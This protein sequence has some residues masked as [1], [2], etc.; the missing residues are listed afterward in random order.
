MTIEL[1]PSANRRPPKEPRLIGRWIVF[2]LVG[3]MG[4][5]IQLATLA[6]LTAWAGVHYLLA[7][8]VAVEAAVLHNFLWHEYWT[9]S[10][11]AAQNRL[12]RWNRL[13]R[14]QITNGAMSIGG[15]LV[16]MQLLVGIGNLNNT[17][18]NILSIAL[19]SILN[20]AASDRL[21]FRETSANDV[22]KLTE[23][24]GLGRSR[25]GHD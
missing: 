24:Y 23:R 4:M 13:C 20:F 3:G 11:R 17:L 19:C 1:L 18:A 7:T 9:W 10:D 16:W 14:F 21:V 12:G 2:S 25:D 6:A 22:F 8:S 15:N 5:V